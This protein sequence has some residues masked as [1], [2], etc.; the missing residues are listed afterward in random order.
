[1]SLRSLVEQ[2]LGIR[3]PDP[4][5][6][7]DW[8]L[9]TNFPLPVWT[10]VVAVI[11]VAIIVAR[12]YQQDAAGLSRMAR[13]LLVS[14]RLLAW[15]CLLF[16]L[17]EAL[18]AVERT[19]LPHLVVMVDTSGSMATDDGDAG[20]PT[21]RLDQVRELLRAND[22]DFLQ[23]LLARHKLR[24]Y[25]VDSEERALG[26]AEI[27]DQA[28]IQAALK[29]LDAKPP[30]AEQSRLG[31]GLRRMLA[32]LRGSPPASVVYFT[33]GVVTDGEKLSAAARFARQKSV[34][35]YPVAVGRQTPARDVELHDMLVDE[36]AFVDDPVSI[37]FKLT[38]QGLDGQSTRVR[39]RLLPPGDSRSNDAGTPRPDPI[40]D[41][42]RSLPSSGKTQR[43]E[44]V[45]TP[46]DVGDFELELE[47]EPLPNETN[48]RNN[49]EKRR[50]SVRKEKTRVL[51]V[52]RLPRWEFRELKT[53]LER[54]KTVDLKVLLQEADPEFSREDRTALPEFPVRREALFEYDVLILGDINPAFLNSAVWD[55]LREFVREKGGGLVLI[56][57]REFT[58]WAWR[59]S[60][61]EPLFPVDLSTTERP[62]PFIDGSVADLYRP[63]PTVEGLRTVPF[64]RLADGELANRQTWDKLP[65]WY[66]LAASPDVKKGAQVLLSHSL[67]TGTTGKLPV[68][69]MQR[70]GAGKCVY[71]ASD[72]TWRWRFRT[73]D[74]YYGRY[75]VQLIRYLSRSKLLG[76]DRAAEIVADRQTYRAGDPAMLRVRYLDDRAIPADP[77]GTRIMLERTGSATGQER[78]ELT[79]GRLPDT[80]T[81]F[82]TQIAAL[83]EGS[84]HAWISSPSLGDTPPSLDFRVE[85]PARESRVLQADYPE[86][87]QLARLTGGK[88][89]PFDKATDLPRELPP[90]KAVPLETEE[91]IRLWN[92][93]LGLSLMVTCLSLEWLLRKRWQ[94]A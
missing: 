31:D 13:G 47:A 4:G 12:V 44:I 2:F 9:S 26:P 59:N 90:G 35:V 20:R 43:A 64:L 84:Y 78:R 94:L 83:A 79:L 69:V 88:L 40:V 81:V 5:Q 50:L 67:R 16:F 23:R 18:L 72:E 15:A 33:D 57:G 7:L 29:E 24:L 55:N 41:E 75:W 61:L 85:S 89:Y 22:R 52:D 92:H 63:D 86:L 73:G 51:L 54:E 17:S 38:A 68:V 25:A 10:L 14:L 74:L 80:P 19:G 62:A 93:W 60:P 6:G 39:V 87:T 48:P 3:P 56:A 76:R 53:L 11:G 65:G 66:G 21:S 70:F 34:A 27:V 77:G 91:P 58:P 28:G 49:I 8:S 30:I 32:N 42:V 1:M 71:H 37:A 46:R 36:V 45:F 82:E